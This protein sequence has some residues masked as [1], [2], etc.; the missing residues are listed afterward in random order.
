MAR[1]NSAIG[2]QATRRRRRYWGRCDL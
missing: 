2:S 1:V